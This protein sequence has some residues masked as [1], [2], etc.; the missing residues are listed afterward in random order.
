MEGN[1]SRDS[2]EDEEHRQATFPIVAIGASAGGLAALEKVFG[3]L[4]DNLGAA[5]V[6]LQH[7][8]PD[9]ESH[10][11]ELLG[12]VTPLSVTQAVDRT[13]LVPDHVYVIPPKKEMILSAGKLLLTDKDPRNAPSLPI[14]TFLRSLG[15]EA[16]DRSVAI[17]LS[18]TGSDGARGVRA[19]KASGGC[20]IAQD[21]NDAEFNGMPESAVSTGAVDVVLAAADIP[22]ELARALPMIAKKEKP[23]ADSPEIDGGMQQI[24]DALADA[25]QVD[26]SCY[27]TT[28]LARRIHRRMEF[29]GTDDPE[30]YA[31]VL[32]SD[33]DESK[34]LYHDLLIGVT[35][36]FRDSQAYEQLAEA[37]GDHLFND[38]SEIRVWVAGCATGEE[39]YS[40]AILLDEA[41]RRAGWEGRI[42]LFAT[43]I[44]A[45]A[46]KVA[47]V[48]AYPTEALAD[49][50]PERLERYF[51]REGSTCRVAEF[52]REMVIFATHNL[53]TDA[54]FTQLDMICCRNVLIYFQPAT[55]ARVLALF[56]FGLRTGGL[57]FLG[58]SETLGKLEDEFEPISVET[59]IF[60]KRRDLRLMSHPG[61]TKIN[62]GGRRR[63]PLSP[64][65]RERGVPEAYAA[66]L[67]RFMPPS[68]LLDSAFH[69]LHCFGG[70]ERFLSFRG[71]PMST[72]LPGLL[73]GRMRTAV[74]G[75][76][77]RFKQDFAGVH[78]VNL[79][80]VGG[81][82]RYRIVV[83][84]VQSKRSSTGSVLVEVHALAPE[85]GDAGT[86]SPPAEAGAV[87]A[88]Y[89]EALERDLEL[90]RGR[91]QTTVEELEAANEE[92]QAANE[93]LVASNEELQST[94]EELRSVNEELNS[95]NVEH[96]KKIAEL[97][98]VT[99]DLQNL[100]H[101]INVGVLFLDAN[102]CIRRANS[103]IGELLHILPQDVGR[104][105]EHFKNNLD[106][107]GVLDTV[108]SVLRESRRAEQE[109]R[110]SDDRVLLLN[111]LPYESQTASGGVVLTL[112]DITSLKA[113]EFEA[114]RLSAI[115]RSARDAIISKSME[116]TIVSWNAGAEK[117]YGY[118]EKEALGRHISLVVPE[119][120]RS[121]IDYI[122]S[123]IASGND[124]P[125]FET[126][127]L[128]RDGSRRDVLLSVA[129]VRNESGAVTAASV[130]AIDITDRKQAE[131]RA[132][133]AVAQR[134]KFLALLSHELRN[135][136]MALASANELLIR[137]E[138]ADDVSRRAQQ[139]ISRQ[140][141][142]MS[143]LLEDTLD[144]SRM[145]HDRI[146]LHRKL[147]D[148]RS[149]VETAMDVVKPRA[150]RES[151]K[152]NVELPA[153]PIRI[154]ADASRLQQM[155]VNLA[156]NAINHS[157]GGQ[158]IELRLFAQRNEAVIRIRDEGVGISA[159][160]LPRLFEPFFQ[161]S[162]RSRE[163]MGLGLS[164]ALSIARAHGGDICARSAGL[165]KGATFEVRLPL[166]KPEDMSETMTDL[167]ALD[168]GYPD[169][170]TVLLVDDDDAS[171]ESVAQLLRKSG[172]EVLEAGTGLEGLRLIEEVMPSVAIL[173]VGLPDI[174]GLEVARRTRKK[175]GSKQIRLIALTGFGRQEDREAAIEAG[176]DM[177]LVKPID[178][179]T[180]EKVIAYHAAR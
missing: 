3:S 154:K 104:S 45:D 128:A 146:E 176:C 141:T 142:Q 164:L 126:V 139:I 77:E 177:H 76:L 81:S 112:V 62:I 147:L 21:P 20:V 98:E 92:L 140:V 80:G 51:V 71:G 8:S 143:R 167:P 175:F 15:Q 170:G 113:A 59:R 13:Q 6:V 7:L 89:V 115:V 133:I 23:H 55:Q 109:V 160:A 135:P 95:V 28:T 121:E 156:Q 117:L 54:P 17:I 5:Y 34:R 14:D 36:F 180:L 65:A 69:L 138:S 96:Q 49:I 86:E 84:P 50:P 32:R 124:V 91:L 38:K 48:G 148:I 158:T 9:F 119:D 179:S 150:M 53:V 68:F 11:T 97:T 73:D 155:I 43:D 162:R 125:P 1:P 87:A 26:F 61:I 90:A 144:A 132:E 99:E 10:M 163:G 134:D 40:V 173:D 67:E 103:R 168:A 18:G 110:T 102:L 105:F 56:H 171:R 33:R 94:N 114:Q 137:S 129:P 12:R 123:E 166:M 165:G 57:L 127:R 130:I 153:E 66:L 136:L 169:S 172:Y 39:V 174:S 52:L 88:E 30:R 116:G 159:E 63:E 46:L 75:L 122:L 85:S 19:I 35:E 145:R 2:N 82:D 60:M 151:I 16:G 27:K 157:A 161:A 25:H 178:F 83:S 107:P 42:R 41:R 22:A 118:T 37:V 29:A 101:T 120:R 108:R 79:R 4:P 100:L 70:A 47:S 131:E 149:I 93:E 106:A 64:A 58:P 78:A 72:A 24:L 44:H 31:A 152:L 74:S 111:A